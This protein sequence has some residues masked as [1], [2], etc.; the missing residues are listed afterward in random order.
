MKLGSETRPVQ[1]DTFAHG[2]DGNGIVR[3]NRRRSPAAMRLQLAVRVAVGGAG[4]RACVRSLPASVKRTAGKAIAMRLTMSVMAELS[5]RSPFM[6]LSRAGVEKNRSRTS[7][8]V[9]RLAAAGRTGE[10]PPRLDADFG[11]A[12]GAARCASGS[13]ASTPSRSTAAPR[14]ESRASGCRECR[15]RAS[16]CSG[17]ATASS[18][19]PAAMPDAVVAH[20]DQR[21]PAA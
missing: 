4:S 19:S 20:P 11:G 14:R 7:T 16:R 17:G 18:S 6:N 3:R 13:T 5:A 2:I 21:Q 1:R 12:V 15:R 8:V 10:T 9:P